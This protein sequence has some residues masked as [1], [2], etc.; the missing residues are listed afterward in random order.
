MIVNTEL[1]LIEHLG[2]IPTKVATFLF[3][4]WRRYGYL[5]TSVLDQPV[6]TR[7]NHLHDLL[8]K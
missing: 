4:Y 5:I 3:P 6:G 7:N 2:K 8:L 1:R